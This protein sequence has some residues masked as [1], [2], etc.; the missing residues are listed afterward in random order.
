MDGDQNSRVG[1]LRAIINHLLNIMPEEG[2][3]C[4]E[5]S[6][7]IQRLQENNPHFIIDCGRKFKSEEE[8]TKHVTRRHGK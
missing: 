7:L 1:D 2:Y 3:T 4:P 6:N 8:L 5:K